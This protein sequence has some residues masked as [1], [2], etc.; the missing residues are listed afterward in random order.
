MKGLYL[1][2]GVK[3]RK[4]SFGG[5][6][7]HAKTGTTIYVDREAYSLLHLLERCPGTPIDFLYQHCIGDPP[8]IMPQELL[9]KLL[10]LRFLQEG[11]MRLG[12]IEEIQEI[13][14][15]IEEEE[16]WPTYPY[17]RAPE[18]VHWALTYDCNHHCDD[19]YSRRHTSNSLL[20]KEEY[21][22][23]LYHLASVGIFQLALGGG[24]PLTFPYLTEV[25]K[26]AANLRLAVHLTTSGIGLSR[27]FFHD[28]CGF[29]SSLQIG[30]NHQRILADPHMEEERI[31]LLIK[32]SNSYNLPIGA[33]LI[34][35]KSVLENFTQLIS[36]LYSCG[37]RRITL[38]RYKPPSTIS[39]WK[40]ERPD[41]K[42]LKG[43]P[44]LL[45]LLG[46]RFDELQFRVDC[47]SSF[48]QN[49]VDHSIAKRRG[50]RG[51]VAASHLLALA[52][53]GSVYPCSQLVAPQYKAGDIQREDLSTIWHNSKVLRSYRWFR[54]KKSFKES[55]CA[56]CRASE[57]C[58]GCRVFAHDGLGGDPGCPTPLKPLLHQ[59]GKRGR[60]LDLK[61]YL[62]SNYCISVKEYMKRYG[63]GETQAFKELINSPYVYK[64]E[65]SHQKS[66]KNDSL[67]C[68]HYYSLYQIKGMIGFT[69]GGFPYTTIEE[70]AE[71]LKDKNDNYPQWLISL[72]KKEEH[73]DGYN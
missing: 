14:K 35:S 43:L 21:I 69:S 16:R 41:Q 63:V 65:L 62:I 49:H 52:P 19:C 37:I 47:A 4:E 13:K 55:W 5:L 64:E 18:T 73:K 34:L 48:L 32:S 58:G 45:T 60:A 61:E 8:A 27:D 26:E 46:K 36:F 29:L 54:T 25:I 72:M 66:K 40:E 10:S 38:L 6:L 56:L 7:F 11:Q 39:R 44:L 15:S 1:V 67:I 70:I 57:Y 2:E 24:E 22:E 30:I 71:G 3:M 17:L 31:T 12:E 9:K 28:V 50:L 59:L 20:K 23:I 68:A 51:C 33:N 42:M 53:D